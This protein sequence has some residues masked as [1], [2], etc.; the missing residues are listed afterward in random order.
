MDG[1]T[2]NGFEDV[3]RFHRLLG[4]INGDGLVNTAD[5]QKA[6]LAYR[7]PALHSDADVDGDGDVDRYDLRFFS[8]F[9]RRTD[10]E[11]ALLMTRDDLDD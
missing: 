11:K 4:D 3:R 9:L 8:T 10:V 7:N 1:D 5:L 6:R 2:S